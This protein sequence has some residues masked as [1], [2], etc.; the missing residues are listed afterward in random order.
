M[1]LLHRLI[2][3]SENARLNGFQRQRKSHC[4]IGMAQEQISSG[5]KLAAKFTNYPA[6][7]G[8]FKIYQNIAAENYIKPAQ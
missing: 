1:D 8:P 3:L 7:N 2:Q 6:L 5:I 4:R